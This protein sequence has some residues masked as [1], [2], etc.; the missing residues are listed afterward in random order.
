ML[1]ELNEQTSALQTAIWADVSAI[2]REQPT[3]VSN[4]VMV[5]LNDV[6]AKSMAERF[7]FDFSPPPQLF[8]LLNGMALLAMALLGYQQALRGP[9]L[10]IIAA[11][12]NL[13]RA[14]AIV[15]IFDLA[16]ARLGAFRTMPA[17]YQWTL[18]GS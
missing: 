7:A 2:V 13:V 16:S 1:N 17:D 8:W 14:V 18:Q 9:R 5:A 11:V 4:S 15:D 12:L 6:F 3:P 10:K